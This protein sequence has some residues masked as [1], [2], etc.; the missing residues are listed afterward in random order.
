VRA[1]VKFFWVLFLLG[2]VLATAQAAG[3]NEDQIPVVAIIFLAGYWLWSKRKK[4]ES[5]H[6][7]SKSTSSP[8]NALNPN[9]AHYVLKGVTSVMEVHSDKMAITPKRN[10]LALVAQGLK[11]TKRI[12]FHSITSIQLKEA[13]VVRGYIQ[14]GIH[15]GIESKGGIFAATTDEN[16]VFFTKKE[17]E[18]AREIHNYIE[19]RIAELRGPQMIKPA[20]NL[21][22]EL[23][24]LAAL[25]A[26]GLL[27]DEEF[28]AAKRRLI[29]TPY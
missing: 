2:A 6:P 16:T 4:K 22:D 13:G 7:Q 23:Q 8:A 27:S 25:N 19:S 24:K 9:S 3:I 20:T 14:F 1:I 26:Q 29:E 17:N 5:A 15:G 28:T 11:G 12:P 10:P 18:L 21:T